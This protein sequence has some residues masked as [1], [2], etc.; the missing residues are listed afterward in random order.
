MLIQHPTKVGEDSGQPTTPQHT[1]TTASSS[2]IV[3][4]PTVASSSQPKKTQ[5]HRKTKRNATK[6][7][8]SS[9]PTTLV[10]DET[11]HEERGDR[12]ERAATIIASLDVEEDRYGNYSSK[13]ESRDVGK[14]DKVKN[15]ITQEE[16]AEIQGRYGHDIEINTASTSITTASINI[17][18]V[19]PVTIVSTPITT[20]GIFVSTATPSTPP[21]TTT[22]IVIKDKDLTIAQTLI[23]MRSEKSKEKAKERGSKEKSSKGKMVKLKKPLKKKEQIEFDKEVAQRLQ[24][25]LQAE[26]EKEER[27]AR[28]KEVDA[29]IAEWDDVQA[30]IDA[31]HELAERLQADEQRELTIKESFEEVQKD[32][33]K[34]MSWINSFVPMDKEVV[35]GSGK[36]AESSAKEADSKKR[37]KKR[38]NEE[39][40]KRQKLEDDVEKEELR[41]CLEIV[42]HDDSA[43]N[44]ESLATKYPIVDWKTH[45]LSEDMFYYHIIISD[46]STKYYKIFNAMLD[47]FDRQ[48]VLDIYTLVK[49]RF[50]TTSPEGYD[51]LLWG[52]LMTLFEPKNKYPLTQ[53]MLLRMLGGRLEIDHECKM[54]YERIRL[55]CVIEVT[56]AS[57]EV[58][59]AGYVYIHNHKDH[60][61]KFDEKAD[62]GYLLGY[63]LVFKAFKVFNTIRKQI[64]ETYHITFD[65]ILDAI[66][67]SKPSVDDINIAE[68]K[69]YPPDEYLHPYEHSQRYHFIIDHILKG[70]NELH[71][72]PTQYQLADIFTK[73]LN[74]PTFKRLIVELGTKKKH[75]K[76]NLGSKE[77]ATKSQPSLK[78]A[79]HSPANHLKKK[80]K[81]GVPVKKEP[82]LSSVSVAKGDPE[83]SAPNDFIPHQQGMDEGT[84]HYTPGHIFAGTNLNVLVDQPTSAG[85]GVKTAH[86]NRGI[87][88]ES[89]FDELS[90]KIK[91]DDLSDLMKDTRS[92]FFTHDSL[93]DELI[94]VSD[95]SEEVETKK[96]KDTHATSY[97]LLEDTLVPY[98]PSPKSA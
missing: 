2:H 36:K 11:I 53:E 47:D 9:G 56:A 93:Q 10:V 25:Q 24:A 3:P 32:F 86:T 91:L 54:A 85:D 62:D 76:H 82:T 77:E 19:E 15:S 42:Q 48:D 64:E 52:D 43:V 45:I 59:T 28:Q 70:D 60:L 31:D 39:S 98:T 13:E 37:A 35:E 61:V 26:L 5:K 97:D 46:G 34:T 49:E 29:N 92:S 20:A 23:K 44:I 55:L 90:K 16:D 12:V 58:T 8:Q 79:A 89:R 68:T 81:S 96:D 94:I 66:K 41:A 57:Y 6:I 22:T 88:E 74:E 80:K 38:L 40:V 87:N 18:T 17:T 67:F 30:M 69:R 14:E 78:E 65:E 4:I 75:S 21:P 27:M 84:K 95:E 51:R 71:V 33:D 73:P 1:P 83:K 50:M 63:S 72:I 7:S